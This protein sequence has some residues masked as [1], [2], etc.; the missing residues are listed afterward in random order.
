MSGVHLTGLLNHWHYFT[1]EGN[2]ALF[3]AVVRDRA[4]W[5]IARLRRA[6][7]PEWPGPPGL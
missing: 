2:M 6:G 4:A 1:A 3:R 7:I 5:E